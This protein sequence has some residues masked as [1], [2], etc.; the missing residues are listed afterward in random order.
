MA[1]LT[2]RFEYIVNT[3]SDFIT[4]ISRNYIYELVNDAYIENIE[5]SRKDI[6]DHHV[7]DVWGKDIFEST[8]KKYIDRCL[9]G[10]NVQYVDR[11]EF[12][13]STKY[14]HV[15][16]YPYRENN[17][18]IS[19][20][21]VFSHDI[22]RLG[23]IEAQLINYE[24]RDPLTGL[25]NGKS[26]AVIL[27]MEL[28][29]AGL[30][31]ENNMRSLLF[32]S[33]S[34]FQ[35]IQLKHGHALGN[36]LL[37]NTGLRIKEL[38]R[39]G[40]Y[41]FRYEGNELVVLLSSPA[42]EYGPAAVAKK[43][44]DMV[45]IPYKNGNLNVSMNCHIGISL[46]PKDS[47]HPDQLIEKAAEALRNAIEEDM[48]YAM[49]DRKV[50]E[51]A[52]KR[53]KLESDMIQAFEKEEFELHFQPIVDPRGVIKGLET[54][55]RW[56]HPEHGLIPPCEFIPIAEKNGLIKSI[57]KW[58]IFQA[59]KNM[60]A[61]EAYPV[62][63]SINL[64]SQEFNDEHLLPILQS[65]LKQEGLKDSGK[66]RLECTE[67]MEMIDPEQ[68]VEKMRKLHDQG[69]EI[70][71]DDFG[72]GFSSLSYLKDLPASTL[73]LD[74]IFIDR[75]VSDPGCR[76]FLRL[77]IHMAENLEMTLIVEGVETREQLDILVE[78]GCTL[79]QGYYFSRPVNRKTMDTLL[80]ENRPLPFQIS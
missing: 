58:V 1:E 25:F 31:E 4:L 53:L 20:A 78:E 19:H 49:Y 60:K 37:E 72:T 67:S 23:D 27:D 69:F 74:K 57:G 39:D 3:S 9:K 15:S 8:I 26:L 38:L 5:K 64:S 28:Q 71:L 6:I 16:Y 52:V 41:V 22:T 79:F 46:Y 40:D 10:E 75:I 32:I 63:I 76:K 21:L 80:K 61:W 42:Q 54:L 12:G 50:H 70:F 2:N 55:I 59:V 14:M 56:E 45:T 62:Y 30:M 51:Y 43:I 24:F 44:Y 66:I 34:N 68:T 77:I 47:D 48:P 35:D 29:K 65:A 13:S 36:T 33:L 73:K 17:G 18:D 7:Q 11:F